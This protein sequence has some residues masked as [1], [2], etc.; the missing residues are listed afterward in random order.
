MK[1]IQF[2]FFP[3]YC[4]KLDS[5]GPLQTSG[6]IDKFNH[7]ADIRCLKTRREK[8]IFFYKNH[9]SYILDSCLRNARNNSSREWRANSSVARNC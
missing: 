6:G 7:G 4:R 3:T 1:L 2:L 5:R 8:F 9:R